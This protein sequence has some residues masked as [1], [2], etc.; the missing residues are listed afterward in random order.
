MKI[1]ICCG[2]LA[3]LPIFLLFQWSYV[4]LLAAMILANAIESVAKKAKDNKCTY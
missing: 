4:M 3:Y 2:Y 1:D